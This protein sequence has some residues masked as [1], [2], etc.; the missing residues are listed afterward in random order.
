MSVLS[1]ST[2]DKLWSSNIHLKTG[3]LS[4]IITEEK[5]ADSNDNTTVPSYQ[6]YKQ[7]TTKATSN[8]SEIAQKLI[9]ITAE[10]AEIA[11]KLAPL[12][13]SS[14]T[15][16]NQL[17]TLTSN[18][19]DLSQ[20]ISG[21]AT[22]WEATKVA[23]TDNYSYNGMIFANQTSGC[24]T[25]TITG[26]FLKEMNGTYTE[27]VTFPDEIH[28]IDGS[29][30]TSVKLVG[31]ACEKAINTTTKKLIFPDSVKHYENSGEN[32][33]QDIV[34][35]GC[36][37]V[38]FIAQAIK[39]LPKFPSLQYLYVAQNGNLQEINTELPLYLNVDEVVN[40]KS[41]NCPNAKY[42]NVCGCANLQYINF[43][44]YTGK[45]QAD[46]GSS[47]ISDLY[48]LH[49]LNL[50]SID[51]TT[52]FN[53]ANIHT[54]NNNPLNSNPQSLVLLM[55]YISSSRIIIDTV[56]LLIINRNFTYAGTT[57]PF[58]VN[59]IL[60]LGRTSNETLKTYF[61]NSIIY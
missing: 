2:I 12:V 45:E 9:E 25:E 56:S 3:V 26:L 10:I 44:N 27:T 14:P 52:D 13:A 49:Y 48:G 8:F 43:E 61:T 53:I 1:V 35:N 46:F 5:D 37:D 57:S 51:S 7:T 31:F 58:T 11:A 23:G 32:D 20:E 42:F 30:V 60:N 6:I 17:K 15:I 33:I 59:K 28:L 29:T 50:S 36:I 22:Y 4:D 41:I 34:A 39:I 55:N 54:F 40:I 16:T 38:S 21:K 19:N 47:N 18:V 24:A